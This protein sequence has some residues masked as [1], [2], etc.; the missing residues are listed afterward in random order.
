MNEIEKKIQEAG[1]LHPISKSSDQI[2]EA[3]QK[4]HPHRVQKRFIFIP[5]LT[6]LLASAC[7]VGVIFAL[8][9]RPIHLEGQ[10]SGLNDGSTVLTSLASDL[11]I[12][13]YVQPKLDAENK[14]LRAALTQPEFNQIAADI[15]DA[16][17]SYAY[18]EAHKEGFNYTFD[19]TRFKFDETNY[20]Y[21]LSVNNTTVYLKD[22]ISEISK[23]GTYEGLIQIDDNYYACEIE[24]KVSRN[25][26]STTFKYRINNYFY[27]LSHEVLNQKTRIEHEVFIDEELCFSN[28]V[29]VSYN[30]NKFTCSI[31]ND[32]QINELKKERTFSKKSSEDVIN[33]DYVKRSESSNVHYEN[34]KLKVSTTKARSHTYSYDGVEDVVL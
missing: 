33:V 1:Q 26:V 17:H 34:I 10:T 12:H 22:N 31:Q 24:S 3:F 21:Q 11:S 28:Y 23:R 9:P 27:T 14:V 13:Y 32:D 25:N 30:N 18:F 15:E 16:Y 2:L 20:K 5:A 6:T 7:A 29:D 4:K 8:N 19:S